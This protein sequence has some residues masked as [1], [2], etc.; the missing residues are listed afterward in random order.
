MKKILLIACS[1]LI[2]LSINAEEQ[3]VTAAAKTHTTTTETKTVC[4]K[5]GATTPAMAVSSDCCDKQQYKE[6]QILTLVRVGKVD[7]KNIE[8]AKAWIEKSIYPPISVNVKKL[9]YS[10]KFADKCVLF[11]E[12]N[13]IKK[14][15]LAVVAL[16]AETPAGISIS[17]S[18]NI[19]DNAGIVYVKPYMTKYAKDNPK[20]ELYKW[21]VN[22]EVLKASALALGLKKCPFPRCCLSPDYDD[23]RIDEKGRNLCPPCWKK[24][25]ELMKSKGITE[26]LPPHIEKKPKQ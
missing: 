19:T 3:K 18:V 4:A 10:K 22:K 13:K 21:R 12:L 25:Y 11:A 9:R 1:A 23:A 20:L 5:P 17:N 26:P 16:V 2:S 24:M 8:D 6:N 7:K 15:N 14:D